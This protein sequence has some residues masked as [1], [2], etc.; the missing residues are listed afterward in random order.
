MVTTVEEAIVSAIDGERLA[1]VL[2]A[3]SGPDL[4]D[5]AV[6]EY[7]VGVVAGGLAVGEDLMAD[8]RQLMDHEQS[9]TIT[10]GEQEV[11]IETLA[12]PP[13]LLVFGAVHIAQALCDLATRLGFRVSVSDARPAF[14]TAERFPAA[15]DLL[16]GWPD[17]LGERIVIDRRTYVVLLS[18]D[19]R[20]EDPVLP[21]VLNSAARYIGAMGSRRT[22]VKRIERLSAAGFSDDQIA[23]IHGPVGLDIGAETPAET[24]VSI[25]AEMIQVRYGAGSGLSL[26][27]RQGRIHLQ[28]TDGPGDI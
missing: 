15:A 12:P 14:I 19:A 5:K 28:R 3:V 27:G 11:F 18:H 2:T 20:F 8:A 1:A 16:V 22:H 26:R 4:G 10:Y 7:E 6:V 21:M 13:R 24:A 25:L 23:R 17:E 9:R